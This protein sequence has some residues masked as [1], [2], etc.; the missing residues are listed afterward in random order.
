MVLDEAWN[1]TTLLHGHGGVRPLHIIALILGIINCMLNGTIC[2]AFY[3]NKR[4][5]TKCHLYIFF[6][7]ALTNSFSGIHL[8]YFV[9]IHLIPQVVSL[10]KFLI[11]LRA[12]YIYI[13]IFAGS[14]C[15]LL[16]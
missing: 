10:K 2:I 12:R 8:I 15:W 3:Y 7:F 13:Y 5:F 1:K 16:S 14:F 9:L 6:V 4:L 11:L